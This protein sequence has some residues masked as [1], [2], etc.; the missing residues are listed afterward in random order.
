MNVTTCRGN[1]ELND[2]AED[3][4]KT[5]GDDNFNDSEAEQVAENAVKILIAHSG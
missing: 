2:A 4:E 1:H 3:D 5:N